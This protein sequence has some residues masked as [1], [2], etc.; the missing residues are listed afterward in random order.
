MR[1]KIKKI[2]K[3]QAW[4]NE[5]TTNSSLKSSSK[6]TKETY[7]VASTKSETTIT[8]LKRKISNSNNQNSKKSRKTEEL[9]NTLQVNRACRY[10]LGPDYNYKSL[11]NHELDILGSQFVCSEVINVYVLHLLKLSPNSSDFY[12]VPEHHYQLFHSSGDA[13]IG[14]RNRRYL[15]DKPIWLVPINYIN[16]HWQL[17]VMINNNNKCCTLFFDSIEALNPENTY[18]HKFAGYG[19]VRCAIFERTN[20]LFITSINTFALYLLEV[21]FGET[22]QFCIKIVKYV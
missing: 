7:Q 12:Y 2:T 8:N 19:R 16:I 22:R 13:S 5:N 4:N 20:E 11:T 14:R 18:Y 17:L 3:V 10:R 1:V 15:Y 9:E 21:A 6:N